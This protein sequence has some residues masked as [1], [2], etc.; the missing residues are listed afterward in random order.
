MSL[1]ALILGAKPGFEDVPLMGKTIRITQLSGERWADWRKALSAEGGENFVA[2]ALVQVTAVDPD[3]GAALF[4]PEDVP[5]LAQ[6]P[7]DLLMPLSASAMR[8]NGL[9]RKN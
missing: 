4:A 8:L 3:T 2:A 6:L 7:L 1:R 5:Q 9:S